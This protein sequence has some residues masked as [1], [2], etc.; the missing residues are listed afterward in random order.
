M[1]VTYNRKDSESANL[2]HAKFK[3]REISLTKADQD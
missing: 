2:H 3:E 1:I